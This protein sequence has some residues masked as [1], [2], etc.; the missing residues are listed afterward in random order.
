MIAMTHEVIVASTAR[1]QTLVPFVVSADSTA[2]TKGLP[3]I[4]HM[5]Y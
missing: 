3:R 4:N 1:Y 2:G 5:L